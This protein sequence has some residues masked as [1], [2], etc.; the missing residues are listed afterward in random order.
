[1]GWTREGDG[2]PGIGENSALIGQF[3]QKWCRTGGLLA[4]KAIGIPSPR[5][6]SEQNDRG[7]G[8]GGQCRGSFVGSG[9]RI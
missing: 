1:M 8:G 6:D 9:G 4:Q 2:S 7:R 3:I 5:I